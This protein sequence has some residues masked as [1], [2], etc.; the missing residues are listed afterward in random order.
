MDIEKMR[1]EFEVFLK[2]VFPNMHTGKCKAE[3]GYIYS[4]GEYVDPAA[5]IAWLSWQA[6]RENLVI[7]LPKISTINNYGMDWKVI[8]AGMARSAIQAAGIK[9]K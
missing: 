6:S 1:D 2:S 9:T 5:Q 8:D 4:I 7:E 3:D